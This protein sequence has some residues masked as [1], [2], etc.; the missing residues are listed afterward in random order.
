MHLAAG[1]MFNE[2]NKR[3]PHISSLI[4]RVAELALGT[5]MAEKF[6]ELLETRPRALSTGQGLF[7]ST[8]RYQMCTHSPMG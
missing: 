8:G 7:S 6:A 3:L 4:K 5:S 2:A 1:Q